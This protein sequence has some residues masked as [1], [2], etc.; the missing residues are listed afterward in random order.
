MT[1]PTIDTAV[2]P[3]LDARTQIA[4]AIE[5]ATERKCHASYTEAF[6]TPCVVLQGAGYTMSVTGYVTYKI[7]VTALYANQ[8]GD[9]G[10][11]VEELARLA[12]IACVDAGAGVFDVPAAGTVNIGSREYA[13]VQFEAQIPVTL[14]SI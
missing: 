2:S 12:V 11:G 6:A 3:L 7:T 13:G 8:S 9:A 1:T 10:E 4:A 14:R 5:A